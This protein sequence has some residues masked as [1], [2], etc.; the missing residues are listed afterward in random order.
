MDRRIEHA[1]SDFVA[2]VIY[3]GE[4]RLNKGDDLRFADKFK[5]LVN[6]ERQMIVKG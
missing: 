1:S 2:S 6:N 3:F 5:S 4:D